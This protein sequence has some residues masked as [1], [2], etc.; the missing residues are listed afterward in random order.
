V[1]ASGRPA[2]REMKKFEMP[3][4]K[5]FFVLLRSAGAREGANAE[6]EGLGI[7]VGVEDA[8]RFF[9][10]VLTVRIDGERDLEAAFLR[11]GERGVE[12]GALAAIRVVRE[13]GAAFFAS[14][15]RGAVGRSVVD[16]ED[17]ESGER[18]SQRVDHTADHGLRLIRGDHDAG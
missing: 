5:T 15:A 13:D 10:G 11:G 9:G 2:K 18:R 7:V 1:S 14:D 17:V 12:R 4:E 8:L 16:D 3:L 6:D